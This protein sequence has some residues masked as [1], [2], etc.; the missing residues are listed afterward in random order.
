M[1]KL[2]GLCTVA[3]LLL[4]SC[5]GS[6]MMTANGGEVTGTG[7]KAFV[8]PTPYGMVLV[9]RCRDRNSRQHPTSYRYSSY[10][11]LRDAPLPAG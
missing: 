6:K 3:V 8:E 5:F 10:N 4:T 7:G 11:R 2:I 9:S 1:K